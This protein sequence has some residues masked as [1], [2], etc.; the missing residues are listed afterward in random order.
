MAVLQVLKERI[1]DGTYALG[2][3]IPT[4][5]QL[6]AE[7]Q[8]S[9][10]TIRRAIEILENEGYVKKKSG[11]GT[12]VINNALFNKM[13][14]DASF[15]SRAAKNGKKVHKENTRIAKVK[16]NP[17]DELYHYF[18]ETCIRITRTYYLDGEPYIYFTHY[19]PGNLNIPEIPDGED[20]QFSLYMTLFKNNCQIASVRDEFY[21][22]YPR[23]QI[24]E[25]LH[26]KA[27]P[28]LGRKR[29]SYTVNKNIAEISYAQYN[30]RIANY[31]V[32]YEI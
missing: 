13:T 23:L 26:L 25:S 12:T 21:I 28:V 30:T 16:L 10:I 8:V 32:D 20:D 1:I 22:D 3:L 7:F 18:G 31:T 11:K 29:T 24:L 15:A 4:E 5:K 6:E 9:K 2:S 17:S 14:K 27:G 19:L